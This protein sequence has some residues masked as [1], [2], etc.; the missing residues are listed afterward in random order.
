MDASFDTT[1]MIAA[2]EVMFEAPDSLGPGID[3]WAF[4]CTLHQILGDVSLFESSQKDSLFS[5]WVCVLG[6]LP[7]E[8]WRTWEGRSEEFEEEGSFKP[9]PEYPDEPGQVSLRDWLVGMRACFIMRGVGFQKESEFES[10]ELNVLKLLFGRILKYHARER[11]G[12][13][14]V[15][16]RQMAWEKGVSV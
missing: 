14:I 11:I 2:P 10:K 5:K 12:A 6:K 4:A 1:L 15:K 7:D 16:L 3:V 13:E 9:D 8:G